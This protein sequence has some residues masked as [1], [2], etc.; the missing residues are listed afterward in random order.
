MKG[1]VEAAEAY[2]RSKIARRTIDE[3]AHDYAEIDVV[4]VLLAWDAETATGRPRVPNEVVAQACTQH[5]ETFVGFGSV[6]PHKGQRAVDELD[7]IAELGLKGV[8]LHPTLQAFAPNEERHWPLYER[9]EDLGLVVLF[10]TGTSGIGAGQPGG[11]G[12]RLD[13]ARPILLD[14]VAAAFPDLKVLA[15]HFGYPW[16]LELLSMALHKTNIYIDISGWAPRYIPLEVIR[17]LRGRLQDQ[18]V[19]G[20]DYPFIQPL[21]CLEELDTLDI[22]EPVLQKVLIDNG[23]RLLGL[24]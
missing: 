9:C 14:P 20:S 23:K 15:A 17:D 10:H 11:Q 24:A 4:A 5:P 8:K 1:Y 21:R 7:R 3:L 13:Y 12:L 19:F 22:P 2:F 6:D 16:H 18:F